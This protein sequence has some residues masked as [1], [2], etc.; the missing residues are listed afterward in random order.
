VA[1]SKSGVIQYCPKQWNKLVFNAYLVQEKNNAM[2][3]PKIVFIENLIKLRI[4]LLQSSFH[5]A[6]EVVIK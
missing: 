6:C 2:I 5:Q 3:Q 1:C 4:D